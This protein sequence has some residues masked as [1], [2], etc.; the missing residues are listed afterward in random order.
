MVPYFYVD[1]RK[2]EGKKSRQKSNGI[3]TITCNFSPN[4]AFEKIMGKI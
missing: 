1:E 2:V 4:V 3:M